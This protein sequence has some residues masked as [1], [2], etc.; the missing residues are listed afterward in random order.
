MEETQ[1]HVG[2]QAEQNGPER[3]IKEKIKRAQAWAQDT[4]GNAKTTIEDQAVRHPWQM[5]GAAALSGFVLSGLALAAFSRSEPPKRRRSFDLEDF[6][7]GAV[8]LFQVAG[9]TLARAR[10]GRSS[11]VQSA[12]SRVGEQV[13]ETLGKV[14]ESA[15]R[16]V[17]D[18]RAYVSE[19]SAGEMATD[20]GD[21]VRRHPVSS[22]LLGVGVGYLLSRGR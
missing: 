2:G 10:G 12:T 14:K 4:I 22:L 1:T 13:G 15:K 20:L 5:A 18:A 6:L 3:E 11:G 16:N 7:I 9:D 19:Q 17:D 21:L 8:Q